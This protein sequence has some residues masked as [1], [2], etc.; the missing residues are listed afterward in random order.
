MDDADPYKMLKLCNRLFFCRTSASI[1]RR[2]MLM[3]LFDHQ[4]HNAAI[5]VFFLGNLPKNRGRTHWGTH[6]FT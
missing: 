5:S 6:G 2:W 1:G 4:Q 3:M